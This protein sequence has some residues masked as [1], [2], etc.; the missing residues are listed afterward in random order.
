MLFGGGFGVKN[1]TDLIGLWGQSHKTI[2]KNSCVL[3]C[4]RPITHYTNVQA[5]LH[6]CSVEETVH[7]YDQRNN[8]TILGH[9]WNKGRTIGTTNKKL[10]I[11]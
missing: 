7:K 4:A 6:H 10:P 11:A 1:E 9:V 5:V 8:R 2:E 3:V